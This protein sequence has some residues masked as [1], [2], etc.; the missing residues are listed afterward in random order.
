MGAALRLLALALVG[1]GSDGVIDLLPLHA[2]GATDATPSADAPSEAASE[3]GADAAPCTNGACACGLSACN[4]VCA[5]LANDPRNCGACGKT[6][7]HYQYCGAGQCHCLPGL[8]LCSGDNACHDLTSDPNHCGSCT[9]A[10]VSGEKC[11][12]S[13]C[14]TGAC[15]SGL[16]GC[17][18]A[19][20]LTACVDLSKGVPYCGDCS[21][22]CGPDQVCA[23]GA[24]LVYA[25]ATPCTTCP[26]AADCA[27]TE[28][29]P[30][31][32]CAPVAGGTQPIC[33]HG[34]ACP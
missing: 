5:D 22:A 15:S 32:C 16:T 26:C 28:G 4:G 13:V 12:D 21:R 8:T 23:A 29:S 14:G 2:D 10:C 9:H 17:A 31:I 1:C 11:D 27:R 33:V 7:S 19:G 25:P 34:T 30:A 20:N 24:C 3:A 18:L 6:C